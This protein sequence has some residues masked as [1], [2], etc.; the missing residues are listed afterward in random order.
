MHTYTCLH[1]SDD[2]AWANLLGRWSVTTIRRPVTI[3]PLRNASDPDLEGPTVAEI[4]KEQL[5]HLFAH[6]NTVEVGGD[7]YRY[8]GNLI[9]ISE[10]A[11]D[12]QMRIFIIGHTGAGGRCGRKATEDDIRSSF[13]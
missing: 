3:P 8:V 7:L 2:N 9:W 13:H 10:D 6:P 1:I 11:P 5:E 4:W 12:L